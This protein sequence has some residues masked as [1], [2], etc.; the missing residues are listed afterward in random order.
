MTRAACRGNSVERHRIS[1]TAVGS[2]GFDALC[3][4]CFREWVAD[5]FRANDTDGAPCER[6]ESLPIQ[7]HPEF[8]QVWLVSR[9]QRSVLLHSFS[10]F[11]ITFSVFEN[12]IY[13]SHDPIDL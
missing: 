11:R 8:I 7:R 3:R 4:Q 6:F 5:G 13:F 12:Q 9:S 1:R 2:N 10:N